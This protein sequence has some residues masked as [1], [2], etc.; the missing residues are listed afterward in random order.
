MSRANIG[1]LK[2]TNKFLDKF[3]GFTFSLNKRNYMMND[4]RN[5]VSIAILRILLFLFVFRLVGIEFIFLV[6]FL[7]FFCFSILL[8]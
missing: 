7:C 2:P 5:N 8:H 4:V 1:K 6:H 3:L